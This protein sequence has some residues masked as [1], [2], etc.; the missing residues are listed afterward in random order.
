MWTPPPAFHTDFIQSPFPAVTLLHLLER[1]RPDEFAGVPLDGTKAALETGVT[2]EPGQLQ[3]ATSEGLKDVAVTKFLVV[4]YYESR[5]CGLETGTHHVYSDPAGDAAQ[6]SSFETEL[7]PVRRRGTVRVPI[8]R[9]RRA[10]RK[11]ELQA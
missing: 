10:R 4:V 5:I 2:W 6:R 1:A 11:L 9:R 7:F 8:H 3:V